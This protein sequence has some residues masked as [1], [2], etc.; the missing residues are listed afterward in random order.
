MNRRWKWIVGAVVLLIALV[1]GGSFIYAKFINKSDPKFDQKAVDSRLDAAAASTTVVGS[2]T[3]VLDPSA[4]VASTPAITGS[5]TATAT[6]ASSGIDGTWTITAP[7]E[8]GYRVKES[9]NGFDTTANGR[10]K[11]ITGSMSASGA[12]ISDGQFTVDMTTFTSDESRRDAQFNERIM[13]VANFPTSTFV[14][15]API[16]FGAVPAEGG[17]VTASATGDLTLHGTTKS[18]T[19]DVQGTFK[20]G[21][22]GV[23]GQ[24]PVLFADYGIPNPSFATTTTE[25]NGLLEFVLVLERK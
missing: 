5:T 25:D 17:T 8:V 6:T 1:V 18:V 22:I 15:T 10:T 3:S 2:S 16:D 14:L 11:S 19:F 4:S 20:N 24:I 7:S 23:L 13:N 12:T 21:L 9:I